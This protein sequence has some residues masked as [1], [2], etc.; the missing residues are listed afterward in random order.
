MSYITSLQSAV[1]WVKMLMPESVKVTLKHINALR[2]I[3]KK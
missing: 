1:K 2:D 3:V